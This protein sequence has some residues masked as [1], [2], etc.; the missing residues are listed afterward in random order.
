[1]ADIT[2]KQDNRIMSKS[3]IRGILMLVLTGFVV[4]ALGTAYIWFS[5]GDG[6]ASAP[7]AAPHL[8]VQAGDSRILFHIVPEQSEALFRIDE[9][10]LGEP[11]TVVGTTHQIAGEMLVDFDNPGNSQVG[12]I[13]INV[14]TLSTD[15]EFRNRALRGQ[16]LEADHDAFEFAEFIP[17][18]LLQLPANLD[19]VDSVDFQIRGNLSV[20]RVTREVTF[21]ATLTLITEDRL[22]GN[23]QTTVMIQDFDITIPEAPGV[24]N[25]S[26]EVQLEI[27]FVAVSMDN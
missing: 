12:L 26:D 23:A 27:G 10:L 9:I 15:N 2:L 20:H 22:E 8:S 25:V 17:T 14:R 16:I 24:A 6:R 4:L 5:G 13:R 19:I 11:K 3:V 7:I 1:M 18:V 21:D